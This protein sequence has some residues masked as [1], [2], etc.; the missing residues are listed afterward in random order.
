MLI[1]SFLSSKEVTTSDFLFLSY[2]DMMQISMTDDPTQ[3][4]GPTKSG[5]SKRGI[6]RMKWTNSRK[7][8]HM[9]IIRELWDEIGYVQLNLTEQILRDQY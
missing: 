3:Q 8:G 6:R 7:K 1:A 9:K 4:V 5:S 2:L